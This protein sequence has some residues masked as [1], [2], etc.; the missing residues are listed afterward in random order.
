MHVYISVHYKLILI[1]F[2]IRILVIIAVIHYT[3]K[4]NFRGSVSAV[5]T[6]F[7]HTQ[8][9]LGNISLSKPK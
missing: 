1:T 3:N 2:H 9:L 4:V 8:N 6:S 7:F 5:L